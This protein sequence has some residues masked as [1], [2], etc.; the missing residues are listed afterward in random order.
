M[1][2]RHSFDEFDYIEDEEHWLGAAGTLGRAR[3]LAVDTEADS[4]HAYFEKVCLVQ[5]ASDCGAAYI[6]DPLALPDL[7]PLRTP[8]AD[9]QVEV[10]FH[11]ADFD[12]TSLRRDFSFEFAGIFDTMVASQLL[13]DEKLSLRDLVERYFGIALEKAQTRTD[14]GRRPLSREQLEYSYLDVAYLVELAAIQRERLEEAD[15]LA[16]AEIE[17]DRL[18]LREPAVREF[19]PHGWMKIKGVRDLPEDTQAVLHELYATRDKHARRM[20]RPTFKVVGND[21]MRRIA[22]EKPKSTGALRS[23]KG[24]S[25][26][27]AGR[28]SR[29]ILGAV[30]RGLSRGAPPPRPRRN[31]DPKRRLDY[32][33]QKRLGKLRDWRGAASER[34]GVTTMAILPNYAMFE[35]ARVRPS[36]DDELEAVPGVGRCRL[37]KWGADILRV[38]R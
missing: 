27:A 29:D 37:E 10:V 16:E 11:G 6:V 5:I 1:H 3:V 31:V 35:V 18:A 32:H 21:A 26:F 17:F 8:L 30:E 9:P 23:L 36:S 24:I 15:L 12:V 13:G 2:D 22:V 25:R 14:W 28:M 20:N 19:D 33:A 7:E 34:S 4:M 38:L